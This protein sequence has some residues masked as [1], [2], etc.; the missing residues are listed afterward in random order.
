MFLNYLIAAWRNLLK[1]RIISV[2]NILGLTLGLASAVLA[3]AFALHEFSYE[4]NHKKADRICRIYMNGSFGDIQQLPT[5]CGPEGE[6][7]KNMFPEIEAYTIS[8]T[9]STTV[10]AGENLFR[11]DDILFSDSMMYA[12]FTIPF[13]KGFPSADPQSVVLS[14][15][16][17]ARY[18]GM[19]NPI[20]KTIRINCYGQHVDFQVTGVFKEFPS[21]TH[22]KADFI[23]PIE[24]TKKFDNW[25]YHEYQ[26]N[27]FNS[28]VLLKQ[29]TVLT[30][31]NKKILEHFKI[32][33]DIENIHISL[34]PLKEIH[35]QGTFENN[36]GKL[37]SFLMGGLFV[38]II[39]CLNYINL[40]NLLFSTRTKETGVRKIN[41]AKRIQIFTQFITDTLL[42][43]LF[44][45]NLAILIL[46]MILPWF[47]S[48]MET[49]IELHF[50][51][52][53]IIAGL[54]LLAVTVIFSGIYPA[55]KYSATRPIQLMRP[56]A[57][58][59]PGRGYSRRIL[60]T[61]QLLLGIIFIQVIMVMDRQ[62]KYL[63][64][65]STKH[66]N[67]DN[68][69]CV[70]GYPWGNLQKIKNE[71]LRS[72]DIEYVSW[73]SN[74]PG[75][76]FSA[77]SDWKDE[78]NNTLAL[79]YWFEPDY[80]N[81]YQIRMKSGRFLSEAY[82]SDRESAVVIN[83]KTA[84]ELGYE[85]PIDKNVMIQGEQYTII[86]VTEDYMS[87]PPI[88]KSLPLLIR[89][90]SELNE[91]LL[92]RIKPAHRESTHQ[93][94]V[95]TLKSVNNDYPIEIKYHDDVLYSTK[96]AKSYISA[97]RLMHIF[98]YLTI[99]T[100]LIG[101]FGLSVFI[102]QRNRKQI[103]IRK[104][105]GASVSGLMLKLS[106]GIII[107]ALIAILIATPITYT[108]TGFYL[109][110]FP[111]RIEP[112]PLFF[113]SGGI[114]AMIILLATVSWQTWKTAMD[115]PVNSLRYE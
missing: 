106:K 34:M 90:S 95:K 113:L 115:N 29:G 6:G 42:S 114:L 75:M 66:Y 5:T 65:I 13:V 74:I 11:E 80:L 68:V 86:G 9:L 41:G 31:L 71:L 111:K 78:H 88:M 110:I 76:G 14:E 8:R 83:G 32:P 92:I 100:T 107:Q 46:K 3:I 28:Y 7:L 91:Y 82:P 39:S 1:N 93:Y 57:T 51:R 81:V 2:I 73:G 43:A 109:S 21:N 59:N 54:L 48:Q 17:A 25:N 4:K 103:G 12:I 79:N 26:S 49:N 96:E 33:M 102:A 62:G 20:G 67:S 64:S 38:L 40:T 104:V 53:M 47:N 55:F 35:F 97:S 72:T 18:F 44:S 23:I 58:A 84:E 69:I 101:I 89:Y 63:D 85:D 15:Q 37:I 30:A 27:S 77:I 50:S 112:G 52:Q 87:V 36:K 99:I 60:T 108:F 105:F 56:G 19:E 94:I 24:F 61:F 70:T 10:R 16:T 22:L 98:F 45:F